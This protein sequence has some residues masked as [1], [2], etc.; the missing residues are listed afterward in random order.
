MLTIFL[1]QTKNF[2]YFFQ[3]KCKYYFLLLTVVLTRNI[4]S[5]NSNETENENNN[6]VIS[7]Y[8]TKLQQL[9]D[10]LKAQVKII[11]DQI[12]HIDW[13]FDVGYNHKDKPIMDDV[14]EFVSNP[15]N[16]FVMIK[17]TAIYWPKLKKHLFNE[18]HMQ[19]WKDLLHD[20]D[21]LIKLNPEAELPGHSTAVE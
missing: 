21:E 8:E 15:I 11:E 7:D 19:S 20:V 13:Y 3:M 9:D 4:T 1:F 6:D 5:I 2:Y 16:V 18:T 12:K 14:D 17:R 10:K